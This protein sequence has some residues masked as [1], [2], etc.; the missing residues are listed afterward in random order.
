MNGI[1][2]KEG[3]SGASDRREDLSFAVFSLLHTTCGDGPL[4][5]RLDGG[6]LLGWCPA[7]AKLQVFV[8]S[9]A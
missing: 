1:D 7:C 3:P 2:E 5:L 6:G 4:E 8:P 9:H